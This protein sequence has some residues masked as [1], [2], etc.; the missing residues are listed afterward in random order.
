MRQT[1]LAFPLA[2]M[3]CCAASWAQN[4]GDQATAGFTN[5][6]TF[7]NSDAGDFKP[8]LKLDRT[9]DLGGEMG[10]DSLA[11]FEGFLL[12]GR[13]GNS[14][15]FQ[16]LD[17]DTGEEQWRVELNAGTTPLDYSPAYSNDIVLLGGSTTTSVAAVRVSTGTVL[18]QDDRVGSSTGRFPILTD[19]AAI[20]AGEFGVVAARPD[21]GTVLWQ[22]P[23]SGEMG[24]VELA[25]APVS[26]EGSRVYLLAAD[27]RLIALDLLTGAEIFWSS[28]PVGGDGSDVIAMAKYV[29]VSEPAE[30]KVSALNTADGSVAWSRNVGD[31]VAHQGISFAY[32]RLFVFGAAG[33]PNISALDPQSGD[34]LW[35]VEDLSFLPINIDPLLPNPPL[36]GQIAN[37]VLYYSNCQGRRVRGLD[38][39]S[40]NIVWDGFAADYLTG[41]T[42][43]DGALYALSAHQVKVY[44]PANTI[45][46]AQLADGSRTSTLIA[47]S[48][49]SP[50]PATGTIEFI[51]DEGDP[52]AVPL[53]GL[54]DA[55]TSIDFSLEAD[56]TTV[57]QTTGGSDPLVVGWA[58]ATATEPIRGTA[59]FQVRGP[60]DTLFEAGVGDAPATGQTSLFVSR[61]A[62]TPLTT[63]STGIAIANP[64]DGWAHVQLTFR[65]RLPDAGVF[66]A[67]L[68]L[69]PGEHLSRFLEELFEEDAPA[70]SEGTLIIESAIPVV[71]TALR[72]ANGYPMSSYPVGIPGH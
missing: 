3:L 28:P 26:M 34:I 49:L 65:R 42:V 61:T 53:R 23:P 7:L 33:A 25:A 27:G 2:L 47:L 31:V 37:N 70:G 55:M 71:V 35:Q 9:L 39:F 38:P 40:G 72:T 52:V 41:M 60:T 24:S 21:D 14:A 63:L 30:G 17:R 59:V 19:D 43:A 1:R 5:A 16:L 46:L 8:P 54:E 68:N 56:E 6:R 66:T 58:R 15:A 57:I 29:Y 32:D 12:V 51:D 45:Y 67:Y 62:P 50:H 44:L 13:G 4:P 18:W 48:N 36:F 64:S 69:N 22:Y 20:Y 11:V 10:A